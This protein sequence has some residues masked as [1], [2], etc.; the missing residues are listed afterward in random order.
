MT[1]FSV[2]LPFV[3]PTYELAG[4]E[5]QGNGRSALTLLLG[6]INLSSTILAHGDRRS[7]LSFPR[8]K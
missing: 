5:A 8:L 2:G 6:N 4:F 7:E 1:S 3:S